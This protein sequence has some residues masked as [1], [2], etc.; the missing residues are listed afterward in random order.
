MLVHIW[1]LNKGKNWN[2]EVLKHYFW[3]TAVGYGN[4]QI[5]LVT[6]VRKKEGIENGRYLAIGKIKN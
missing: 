5:Y 1:T 4:E 3:N 6:A 2:Y